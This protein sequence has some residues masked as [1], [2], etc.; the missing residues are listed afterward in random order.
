MTYQKIGVLL[1]MLL[2]T[3][4]G[5]R[6]VVT[7]HEFVPEPRPVKL[8]SIYEGVVG[9]MADLTIVMN[10]FA[11]KQAAARG[12]PRSR[13]VLVPH[14]AQ[15]HTRGFKGESKVK[16]GFT[17]DTFILLSFGYLSRHKGL[18]YAI[19]ALKQMRKDEPSVHLVIAGGPHPASRSNN[20]LRSLKNLVER[21]GLAKN[22]TF[23][24]HVPDER[25]DDLFQG[26]DL[27]L[28]PHVSGTLSGVLCLAAGYGVP[29]VASSVGGI[30]EEVSKHQ[31]GVVTPPGRADMLASAV[32]E[33]LRNE[34]KR[35]FHAEKQRLLAERNSWQHVAEQHLHLYQQLV[36]DTLTV[37]EDR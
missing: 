36:Q 17:S 37:E 14:G 18:E 27:V 22:V 34:K 21:E 6:L 31:I 8:R 25:V 9:K 24:G 3:L 23:T 16:I 13:I 32:L 33:L 7:Q 11:L 4:L 10:D 5:V 28:L 15:R 29:V 30:G 35:Q 20:Y 12:V 2:L 19:E 1:L 26:A